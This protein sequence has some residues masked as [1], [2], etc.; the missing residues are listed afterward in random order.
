MILYNDYNSIFFSVTKIRIYICI[1]I[2]TTQ[3]ATTSKPIFYL[4]L[5]ANDLTCFTS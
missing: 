1:Y 5:Q 2:V 4:T 3:T